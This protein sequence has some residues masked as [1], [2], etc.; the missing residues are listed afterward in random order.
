M[1]P[2]KSDTL[3]HSKEI[4][5]VER[6]GFRWHLEPEYD[7]DQLHE[8]RWVQVRESAHYAPKEA[9][10]RY[11]AQMMGTTFPP[12]VV[13]QDNYGV[14]GRTR[15][16]ARRMRKEKFCTAIVLEEKFEGATPKRK[17]E[18][19]ALAATLNSLNGT[20][21]TS[22]EIRVAV[23]K[24][25]ALDWNTEQIA[26]AIGAA[27]GVVTQVRKEIAAENRLSRLNVDPNESKLSGATLRAI[28][29]KDIVS[30]NDEPFKG[31]ASLAGDAGLN[32]KE[33]SEIGKELRDAG[34]DA[35]ALDIIS[36]ERAEMEARIRE[37]KLTGRGTPPAS[38]MLRQR[39]GWVNR[40]MGTEHELVEKAEAA[41]IN[42]LESMEKAYRV[43]GNAI[44]L[45]KK[46]MAE[47]GRAA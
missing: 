20:A 31:L 18:M 29:S 2:S 46:R 14:D 9:V 39:L 38:R 13:T 23:R 11:A 30:M 5:E 10:E 25:I 44:E 8:T 42:H 36:R 27:V 15:E 22:K 6:L 41:E 7:L 19:F 1:S 32:A 3:S 17:D 45:Q 4:A 16:Q 35:A 28:G 47:G 24:F 33:I 12:I 21:L 26:R 43:L 40:F 34:S 37:R